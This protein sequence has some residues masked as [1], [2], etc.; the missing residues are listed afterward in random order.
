MKRSPKIVPSAGALSAP[1]TAA[2]VPKTAV[3]GLD[4]FFV[5]QVL[6]DHPF[7]SSLIAGKRRRSS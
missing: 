7:L 6:D 3:Q 1:G 2:A 4:P 5:S